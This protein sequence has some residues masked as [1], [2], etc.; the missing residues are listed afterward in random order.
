MNTKPHPSSDYIQFELAAG[1][2]TININ[3]LEKMKLA[4]RSFFDKPET[5]F[6]AQYLELRDFFRAELNSS[7]VWISDNV[8]HV[9]AWTL[10]NQVGRLVLVR[11]PPPRN[12]TM[13]IFYAMLEPKDSEW[14]V[15]AFEV[16]REFGPE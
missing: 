5:E 3:T 9:G 10:Q 7:A 8:A 14:E 2:V 6:P 15:V 13:Y 16:E 12:N 4:M 1:A 11:Y